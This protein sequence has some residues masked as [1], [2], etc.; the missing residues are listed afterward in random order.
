M[1]KLI[2]MTKETLSFEAAHQRLEK[3]LSI[4]N[5]GKISLEE[6]LDLFEQAEALMRY[7]EDRLKTA[8]QRID[9][10]VKG[11]NNEIV[12]DRDQKPTLTPFPGE[13]SSGETGSF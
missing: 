12:L 7:C 4:M 9:E 8:E 3:I 6:S 11:K 13:A 2:K 1:W 10:I 5:E